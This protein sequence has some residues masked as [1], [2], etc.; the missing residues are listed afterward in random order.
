MTLHEPLRLRQIDTRTFAVAGTP[1]DC[2]IMAV[3]HI[4]ME[5]PPDL[6]LSGINRG[7]NT[8][9]RPSSASCSAPTS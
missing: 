5:Q 7:A 3:R 6:V 2:V 1:T 8:K 9:M 4:L